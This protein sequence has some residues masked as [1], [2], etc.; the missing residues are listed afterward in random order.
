MFGLTSQNMVLGKAF[1]DW[2]RNVVGMFEA[3]FEKHLAKNIEK[4]LIQTAV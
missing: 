2:L 4:H 1:R 3:T